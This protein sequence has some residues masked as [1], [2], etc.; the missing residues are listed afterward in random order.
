MPTKTELEEKTEILNIPIEKPAVFCWELDDGGKLQRLVSLAEKQFQATGPGFFSMNL[1][2]NEGENLTYGLGVVLV[3]RG[4]RKALVQ[5]FREKFDL[6]AS[7]CYGFWSG[8]RQGPGWDALQP[9]LRVT[10]QTEANW[11]AVNDDR[12]AAAAEKEAA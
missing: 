12:E 6:L 11:D 3:T 9:Q 1:Q 2:I 5:K 7:F 4:D 8:A 10:W